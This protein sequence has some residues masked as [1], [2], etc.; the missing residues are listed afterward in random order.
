MSVELVVIMGALG[1][2]VLLV[3]LAKFGK[4]LERFVLAL[5]LVVLALVGGLALLTQARATAQ[6]TQAVKVGSVGQTLALVVIGA[7]A[8]A[9][10][11]VV[12]VAGVFW[13]RWQVEQRRK[14]ERSPRQRQRRALPQRE[15]PEVVY[16]IEGEGEPVPLDGV[17][18]EQWGW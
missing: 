14:V 18:L 17:D 16:I 1:V 3:I 7:L 6:A 4:A 10:V 9:L 12:G 2:V 15:A 13:Y 5:G 11:L 8:L